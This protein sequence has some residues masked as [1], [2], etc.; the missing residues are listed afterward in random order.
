MKKTFA[1]LLALML[2]MALVS[3]DDSSESGD[4]NTEQ[5]GGEQSG[6]N[7]TGD[8]QTG[9]DQT[10]DD[11]TGDDQT[12]GDQ[13]GN[14][15]TGGDQTGDDQT[16]DD[17][18]GDDQTGGDDVQT[19]E[20]DRFDGEK[21]LVYCNAADAGKTK[22]VCENGNTEEVTYAISATCKAYENGYYYIENDNSSEEYCSAGCKNGQC[23]KAVSDAG[24]AC[25]ADF[26]ERCEGTKRVFCE[27]EY[28]NQVATY[29]CNDGDTHGCIIEADQ[30][31][32][33]AYSCE[34]EGSLIYQCD[35]YGGQTDIYDMFVFECKTGPDGKLYQHF[36]ESKL[37]CG[38]SCQVGTGVCQ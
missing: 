36:K 33:C 2:P 16:G 31:T 28:S 27:S 3:C 32:N 8:D 23:I 22:K 4:T 14:D 13:T 37:S 5:S 25:T 21:G 34:T 19:G 1:I 30:K 24:T 11:Q 10:G 20:D 29:D 9:G 7:Q 6:S 26:Q 15:Q 17:Q 18:T 38:K 35:N 12:G